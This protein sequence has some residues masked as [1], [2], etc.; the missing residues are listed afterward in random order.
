MQANYSS[1][2]FELSQEGAAVRDLAT[3]EAEASSTTTAHPEGLMS[4]V[5]SVDFREFL[6]CFSFF[7]ATTSLG[8][9]DFMTR[10]RPI[11]FWI[12][13]S[14]TYQRNLYYNE[15]FESETVS[16][17]MLIVLAVIL[18]ATC[19]FIL[20]HKCKVRGDRH[21]T[22]CVYSLAMALNLLLVAVLKMYVGY[23]RPIFYDICGPT[24]DFQQCNNPTN[25]IRKSFPSGHASTSFSGLLLLTLYV[26]KRWGVPSISQY[27][28]I[29]P[30]ENAL[31]SDHSAA[32]RSPYLARFIS[33]LSLAP[34]VLA[35]F[36][37]TSRIV[38][39]KHHPADV[40]GGALIGSSISY[41][42]HHLWF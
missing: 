42:V 28:T 36:I 37:A 17:F 3:D 1:M 7:F 8:L 19:Q 26:H 32:P 34:L 29:R 33:I 5:H 13:G 38:D 23:L 22:L 40:V 30:H 15:S 20:A 6:L 21:S 39:N 11:P 41:F 27:A 16:D 14:G 10:Q 2:H 35:T 18:P 4:Y 31:S 12:D 25:E 9:F 24:D